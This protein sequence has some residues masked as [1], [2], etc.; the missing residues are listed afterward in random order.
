M[1]WKAGRTALTTGLSSCVP[2]SGCVEQGAGTGEASF[3][4]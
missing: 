2:L 1:T 3:L 4:P